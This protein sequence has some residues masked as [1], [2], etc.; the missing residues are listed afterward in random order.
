MGDMLLRRSSSSRWLCF[1]GPLAVLFSLLVIGVSWFVNRSW[2]VYTRDAF[3]DLGGYRS[4]APWI[5]N[6][7]LI[8]IGFLIVLFSIC[9][10]ILSNDKYFGAGASQLGL[11]G[12]FLALIGVFH[13]GT[14]PHVFVSFWFFLQ[15]NVALIILAYSFYRLGDRL[16]LLVL[17]VEA[18]EFP[19]GILIDKLV[20]WPSAAVVESYGIAYIYLGV[21]YVFDRI[22]KYLYY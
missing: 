11:A 20:G 18:L 12:V 9:I 4:V 2:F 1:S 14:R 13:E 7:G 16:G 3:S 17:V 22:K 8:F 21:I 15:M 19:L 10:F 5:Y 6:Y